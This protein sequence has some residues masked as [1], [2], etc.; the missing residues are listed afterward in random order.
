[1]VSMVFAFYVKA[2][3]FIAN[4]FLYLVAQFHTILQAI[5][6]QTEQLITRLVSSIGGHPGKS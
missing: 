1:M 4:C 3:S 2:H 6:E 5:W